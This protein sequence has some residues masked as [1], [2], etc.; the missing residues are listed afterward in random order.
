MDLTQALQILQ[1]VIA[2]APMPL[3]GHQQAQEALRIIS[4]AT[5]PPAKESE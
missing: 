3:Q 4:E 5:K 1:Q 2:L